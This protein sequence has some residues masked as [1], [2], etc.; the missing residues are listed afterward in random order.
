ME[1]VY[2]MHQSG[3]TLYKIG[4][5]V[6]PID[7]VCKLQTGNPDKIELVCAV[8]VDGLAPRI[9]RKLQ[10]AFAANLVLGEWYSLDEKEAEYLSW[11]VGLIALARHE[12]VV[13]SAHNL[14]DEYCN[15]LSELNAATK[16][17]RQAARRQKQN[18]ERF[19]LDLRARKYQQRRRDEQGQQE[20]A[21]PE[22]RLLRNG[23]GKYTLVKV[24]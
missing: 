5:A 3:S 16:R 1:F 12:Q 8:R 2:V 21:R 9:E 14:E 15:P 13:T 19:D 22:F 23:D 17:K 7:R 11:L 24:K 10:N 4:R 20:A 18:A 6:D